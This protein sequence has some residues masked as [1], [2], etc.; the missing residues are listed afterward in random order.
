MCALLVVKFFLGWKGADLFI[1]ENKSVP[2]SYPSFQT[3]RRSPY[4]R[5]CELGGVFI[6]V[7]VLFA[8]L[9]IS[10]IASANFSCEADLNGDGVCDLYSVNTLEE[11]STISRITI[12][13]GGS[14]KSVSGDFDLGDGGLSAGYLSSDFSLL[15]DFYTRNTAITKYNFRWDS[16]RLDWVLY[17]KST[18][19]EPSRDEKYSLG[20]E[21]A[22][23]EALFPQQ[24]DV[25]RVA[26]CTLFSQFSGNGQNLKF[27][28][29]DEE[30]I[31]IRKD[32]KYVVEN[33]PQGEKGKLFYSVDEA[34]NKVRRNIPQEFVYEMTLIISDDNVGALND[35][36]YYLSRSQNNVLAALLLRGIH[37]KYPDRVVATLNLADAYW[38]IGMKNDACPLYKEYA[39]KMA[40]MGKS[41]RIPTLVKSRAERGHFK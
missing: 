34:G 39:N 4:Y 19:V 38:D 6:K 33:L 16:S 22:P 35:Y 3:V 7:A 13:I 1:A 11:D 5:T 24:F 30:L 25:Q 8:F 21:K 26:C 23:I 18:W 27:L 29:V 9:F 14:K 20:G 31:E 28:S 12:N 36:A 10:G 32:F 2:V 37:K 15:L 17:K 40:A 41:T